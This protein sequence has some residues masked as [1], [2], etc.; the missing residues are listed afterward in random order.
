VEELYVI[1]D[2]IFDEHGK[3]ET[4]TLI[5]HNRGRGTV[6]LVVNQIE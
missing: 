1:I 3:G 5:G 2:T 4:N 6:W